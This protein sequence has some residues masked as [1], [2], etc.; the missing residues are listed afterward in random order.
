M[1]NVSPESSS[2]MIVHPDEVSH[3]TTELI[4]LYRDHQFVKFPKP[5]YI[6]GCLPV[7]VYKAPSR[8]SRKKSTAKQNQYLPRIV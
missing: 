7:G 4:H 2:K 3:V 5:K 1:I 6:F 8:T